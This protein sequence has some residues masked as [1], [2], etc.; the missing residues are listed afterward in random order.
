MR[1]NK[2]FVLKFRQNLKRLIKSQKI[3]ILRQKVPSEIS[4]RKVPINFLVYRL[5][6]YLWYNQQGLTKIRL[7]ITNLLS[8]IQKDLIVLRVCVAFLT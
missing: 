2:W 7:P 5:T 6:M 3:E 1:D 4:D 8:L